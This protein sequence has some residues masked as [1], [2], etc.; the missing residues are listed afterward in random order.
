MVNGESNVCVFMEELKGNMVVNGESNMC[1]YLW[2]RQRK[3]G[4]YWR[5]ECVCRKET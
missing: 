5:V 2:K 1:V 4:G 3:H